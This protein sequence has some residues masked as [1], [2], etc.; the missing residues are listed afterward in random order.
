MGQVLEK[1]YPAIH[2]IDIK[3]GRLILLNAEV[4]VVAEFSAGVWLLHE[5]VD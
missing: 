4:E 5:A 2:S 3:K 1:I